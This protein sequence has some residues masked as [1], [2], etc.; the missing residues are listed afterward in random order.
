ML[1]KQTSLYSANST[2]DHRSADEQAL[3]QRMDQAHNHLAGR[4]EK[5]VKRKLMVRNDVEAWKGGRDG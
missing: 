5:E 1:A 4:R 3:M 2:P